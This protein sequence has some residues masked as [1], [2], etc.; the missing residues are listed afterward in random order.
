M[1]GL[2]KFLVLQRA[3]RQKANCGPLLEHEKVESLSFS[4]PVKDLNLHPCYL[5]KTL[6]SG[7][8]CCYTSFVGAVVLSHQPCDLIMSAHIAAEYC[9]HAT[10][11]ELSSPLGTLLL[12]LIVT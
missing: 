6:L 4:S 3:H 7:F 11:L 1:R 5:S 8:C 12:D 10:E 9:H 2:K